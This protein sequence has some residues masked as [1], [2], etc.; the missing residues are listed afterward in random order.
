LDVAF[1]LLFT[2]GASINWISILSVLAVMTWQVL[3]ISIPMVYITIRLQ[4]TD[5]FLFEL[6]GSNDKVV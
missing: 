6:Y 3:F 4:V 1:A 2:V 5:V